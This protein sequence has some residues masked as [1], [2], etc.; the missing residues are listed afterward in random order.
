VAA[1]DISE[2]KEVLSL[3]ENSAGAAAAREAAKAAAKAAAERARRQ[4][5][6]APPP[7][8]AS[9][10]RKA[11]AQNSA[12]ARQAVALSAATAELNAAWRLGGAR[13]I[14]A[15]RVIQIRYHPDR[16]TGDEE[17]RQIAEEISRLANEYQDLARSGAKSA[18]AMSRR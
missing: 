15:I 9:A 1:A 7:R 12:A 4:A 16:Q 17:Q 10:G 11:P 14:K 13:R 2:A 3:E 5:A 6:Q 18:P 8:A